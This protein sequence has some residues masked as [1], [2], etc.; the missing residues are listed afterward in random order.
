MTVIVHNNSAVRA[1]SA[2]A[3]WHRV[4]QTKSP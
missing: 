2:A 3:S 4:P 1:G